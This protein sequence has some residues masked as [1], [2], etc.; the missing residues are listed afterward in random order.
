MFKHFLPRHKYTWILIVFL[1]YA[2]LIYRKDYAPFNE[3]KTSP[4]LHERLV[5]KSGTA[6]FLEAPGQALI[7]KMQETKRGKAVVE[8]FMRSAIEEK[9][10]SADLAVVAGSSA[11]DVLSFDQ[12]KGEGDI[13]LC[14]SVVSVEAEFLLDNSIVIDSTTGK[15]PL[16]FTIG[17]KRVIPGLEQGI[18]GMRVGGKRKLIIP[19]KFAYGHPDFKSNVIPEDKPVTVEVTLVS[20]SNSTKGIGTF[21]QI[22]DIVE[23]I[24]EGAGCG[25]TV[26]TTYKLAYQDA[27]GNITTTEER[28][29]ELK[30]GD[31]NIPV[32][33][34]TGILGMR[35]GGTRGIV[36]SPDL[37]K[38]AH[39]DKGP[40]LI[41][42]SKSFPRAPFITMEVK[43]QSVE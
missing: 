6:K 24:G 25:Q 20:L 17:A 19:P 23:G 35:P 1:I 13:A 2:L 22:T 38:S 7:E 28:P 14:S 39:P 8:A 12:I 30:L 34:D 15:A 18:I 31:A 26:H 37:Q 27:A 33:L 21:P 29:L 5:A 9:Y 16:S 11:E 32:G 4:D 3:K 43:L 36:V 10:G 40:P 42:E 41:A